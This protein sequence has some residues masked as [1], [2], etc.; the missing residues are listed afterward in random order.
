M[1]QRSRLRFEELSGCTVSS[2]EGSVRRVSMGTLAL[3]PNPPIDF[4]AFH[5]CPEIRQM[6]RKPSRGDSY[7]IR[8]IEAEEPNTGLILYL[9]IGP[10][11]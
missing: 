11:I 7:G 10:N 3:I 2:L 4:P 6:K 9:H 1:R 5:A 8:C